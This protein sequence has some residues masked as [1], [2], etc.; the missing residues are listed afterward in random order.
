MGSGPGRQRPDGHLLARRCRVQRQEHVARAGVARRERAAGADRPGDSAE[1]GD[2]R[3]RREQPPDLLQLQRRIRL[4]PARAPCRAQVAARG[5]APVG[6]CGAGDREDG[7]PEAGLVSRHARRAGRRRAGSRRSIP[8]RCNCSSTGPSRRSASPAN[9]RHVRS[10]GCDRVL[11][12]RASTRRTPTRG[13]TGS[14]QARRPGRRIAV[15]AGGSSAAVDA[16]GFLVDAAAQGS[17]RVLRGAQE[18]RRRELVRADGV[19]GARGGRPRRSLDSRR[20]HAHAAPHR[21]VGGRARAADRRAAGRDGASRWQREPSCRRAGQRQH[22]RRDGRSPGR[23]HAEQTFPVDRGWLLDGEN[24]VTL[25]ARGGDADSSLVDAIRLDYPHA[26][27]ADADRLRFTVEAPG[28]ITVGGFASASI[29]VFDITDRTAPVRTAGDDRDRRRPVD[30]DGARAGHGSA[31]ADGVLRR[32][33]RVAGVRPG[34][35][36][37]EPAREHERVRLRDHLARRLHRRRSHRSRRT[38]PAAGAS[39]PSSS[40]SKTSTTSSASAR[41]RRRR[42]GTSCSGRGRN[43][44]TAPKFVVLAGD[45]TIDPRDYEGLGNADFVPTKQVPMT[46]VA[47]ETASDDWFVDFDDNGLP[48]VA[49]GRLSVRTAR[50][51][52][53]MVAKIVGYDAPAAP[54]PWTKN[55]L[56]VA[57]QSDTAELRAIQ[58]QPPRAAAA[59]LHRADGLPAGARRRRRAPGPRRSGQ[60]R[61]ADRQLHGTR[62]H[63]HL[64]QQ[65]QPADERRM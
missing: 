49:I 50:Q 5:H 7:H 64:E 36:A 42:S 27:Q 8:A 28:S 44:A 19:S 46:G 22:R 48:D 26:Y 61:A 21:S 60:R 62:F 53:A 54:Q 20:A 45:A 16:D 34:E 43:W 13:S 57:D 58:R 11:R 24:T 38:A 47:L 17:Q 30:G 10:R 9:R 31:D 40:T 65:P 39:A 25:E 52:E 12:L 4:S 37:V 56:L 51:A 35:P 2:D 59:G 15:D 55:V 29:R 23:T 41:R 18:W 6:A 33:R 3:R 63:R 32:D 14:R 1:L